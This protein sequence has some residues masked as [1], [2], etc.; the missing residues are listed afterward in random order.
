MWYLI[1]KKLFEYKTRNQFTPKKQAESTETAHAKYYSTFYPVGTRLQYCTRNY[2]TKR[3]S[4]VTRDPDTILRHIPLISPIQDWHVSG[5]LWWVLTVVPVEYDGHVA[6]Q[7]AVYG[8]YSFTCRPSPIWRTH[9]SCEKRTA[10][11]ISQPRSTALT[12]NS[13]HFTLRKQVF[14]CWLF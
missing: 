8:G 12:E 14:C 4:G 9:A 13:S 11:K 3:K 1:P 6:Q 10:N 5:Q 7:F 2:F